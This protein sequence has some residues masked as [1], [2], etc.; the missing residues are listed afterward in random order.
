MNTT[1]ATMDSH[2]YKMDLNQ[3]FIL[4]QVKITFAIEHYADV[5]FISSMKQ[6]MLRRCNVVAVG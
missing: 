4:K 1:A 6:W 3:Q 5:F 2:M